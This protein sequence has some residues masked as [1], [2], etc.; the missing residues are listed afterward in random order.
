[1]EET[2]YE[3]TGKAA[4]GDHTG[5]AHQAMESAPTQELAWSKKAGDIL[6][7]EFKPPSKMGAPTK[8][9]DDMPQRVFDM[10]AR[11]DG[12]IFTKKAVAA[13]LGINVSTLTEWRQAKPDLSAAIAQGCAVQESW[14]ASQM[15]GGLKYSQSLFAVL[16]NLHSW[17]MKTEESHVVDFREAMYK[18][19]HAAKRVNWDRK[20]PAVIDAQTVPAPAAPAP[21]A[22]AP[23]RPLAPPAMESMPAME[24]GASVQSPA[25]SPSTPTPEQTSAPTP[26]PLAEGGGTSDRGVRS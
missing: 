18:A 23:A 4:R 5:K 17:T 2:Q 26:E 7:C 10:L 22:P 14:M 16:V 12:I 1:M 3:R 25:L 19:S 9:T 8:Y 20:A 11:N 24:Q 13:H 15:A 21:A 6:R